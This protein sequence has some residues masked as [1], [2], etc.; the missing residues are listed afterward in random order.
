VGNDQ[1]SWRSVILNW[2]RGAPERRR[3]KNS[4]EY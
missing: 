2:I 1:T 3:Q 4:Q